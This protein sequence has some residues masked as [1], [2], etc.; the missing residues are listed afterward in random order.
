MSAAGAERLTL[1]GRLAGVRVFRFNPRG[2]LNS[3]EHL[4]FNL[5]DGLPLLLRPVSGVQ[6]RRVP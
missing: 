6:V 5:D 3:S 2:T 4:L 1:F